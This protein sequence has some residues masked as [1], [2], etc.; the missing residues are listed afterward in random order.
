MGD[1]DHGDV[2]H[3]GILAQDPLDFR[4]V[5]IFAATDNHIALSIHEPDI[6]VLV[7]TRHIAD[8]APSVAKCFCRFL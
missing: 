7:A 8:R 4:R 3:F 2:L 5:D 1:A 6:A